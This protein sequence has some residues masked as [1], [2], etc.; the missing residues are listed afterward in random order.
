MTFIDLTEVTCSYRRGDSSVT[1]LDRVSLGIAKGEFIVMLGPSGSGKTTLLHLLSGLMHPDSGTI[2]VDT[3]IV[4][5]LSTRD[6]TRWRAANVGYVF[7]QAHLVPTLTA[8]ENVELPLFLFPLPRPEREK[9]V[10]FALS[11]VGLAERADHLPRQLS[12][13]Q[14]QRVAI[15]R[16]IVADPPLLL[17]DEPTGALDAEAASNVLDLLRRLQRERAKTLVMVTHDQHAAHYGTRRVELVKGRLEE[18]TA[19]APS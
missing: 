6:A 9:R 18:S 10:S 13:G 2:Q 8:F 7:Q 16:A 12:G 15:A 5:A 11:L 4:N 19:G 1:V 3:T 17:V 14:E